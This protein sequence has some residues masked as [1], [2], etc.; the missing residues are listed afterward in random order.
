PM[1]ITDEN[2]Q[3]NF[4]QKSDVRNIHFD[5][6]FTEDQIEIYLNEKV[7]EMDALHPPIV[8]TYQDTLILQKIHY[9]DSELIQQLKFYPYL[10]IIIATLFI[11][12][13]YVGFSSIKKNE[14]SN[15]WVGMAKETA[16]QF[17]TPISSLMGWLEML[18]LNYRR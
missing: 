2:N 7:A 4:A 16:H 10:Q 6:T 13:G 8:V 12:I 5:S 3:I 14:Q 1:I 15:I 9:G 11:I 17:G 18:K